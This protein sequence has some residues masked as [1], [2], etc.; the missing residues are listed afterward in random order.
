MD[1]E[2]IAVTGA[3][4][5]T[6]KYIAKRLLDSGKKVI[7]LTGH[8]NNLDPFRN[9]V[10]A[11]PFNFE[12]P[13]KLAESLNGVS[14][15]YNTYWVRFNHGRQ[16][17]TRAVRNTETLIQA[18]QH[19]G[20]RRIVHVSITNPSEDS[21]YLYFQGKAL[22]EKTIQ[23]SGLTYA[24]LRPTVIFGQ[25]D[26]LINNIAYMLRKFKIFPV[27]GSG[28]YKLQPIYVEDFA[29]IAVRLG[30]LQENLILDVVGPEV[31][32]FNRLIHLIVRMINQR[33]WLVH[34]PPEVSLFLS[35]MVGLVLRD[36]LLTRDEVHGL[37]DNLLVSTDPPNGQTSL[38]TWLKENAGQ[39][40]RRYA[41]EL[42]RHY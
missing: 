29:D 15:L 8:P 18:A 33:V 39:I 42:K 17:Y 40:G 20:L 10:R 30:G 7:T 4:G 13:D 3:F 27:P 22:L 1:G 37:M 41:S 36:I 28:E 19:A 2:V 24:I 26:L 16:N 25:G 14:T 9:Q 32:T 12:Y 38:S 23:N 6:G 11:Y 5:Y 21:P 31:F 34:V 35:G